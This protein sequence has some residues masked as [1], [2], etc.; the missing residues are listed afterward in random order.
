MPEAECVADNGS[1]ALEDLLRLYVGHMRT[2]VNG[3]DGGGGGGV[4]GGRPCTGSWAASTGRADVGG[5][6]GGG[7]GGIGRGQSREERGVACK[8][9]HRRRGHVLAGWKGGQQGKSKT[10]WN[11]DNNLF[12]K[13]VVQLQIG[14]TIEQW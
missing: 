10:R 11:I 5:R 3:G 1:V 8:G 12:F 7:G 6:G 9:F 2:A 4:G 13:S 14:Y